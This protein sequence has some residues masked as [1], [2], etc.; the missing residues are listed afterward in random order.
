MP[1]QDSDITHETQPPQVPPQIHR[2]VK[3]PN[4]YPLLI[5]PDDIGSRAPLDPVEARACRRVRASELAVGLSPEVVGALARLASI[6]SVASLYEVA[7][8]L[9]PLV[10]EAGRRRGW[11][12]D[13]AVDTDSAH[14]H[15]REAAA[16]LADA[17]DAA[18]FA[19]WCDRWLVVNA[20][21]CEG[22]EP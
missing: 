2:D 6:D 22:D 18:S 21:V 9:D 7:E 15:E 16:E 17:V 8:A 20:W 3:P 1:T 10:L 12:G 19:A 14:M 5:H 11:S 4:R 13:V